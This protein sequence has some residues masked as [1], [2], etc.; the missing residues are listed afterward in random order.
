MKSG[1][2]L[3]FTVWNY[4][5]DFWGVGVPDHISHSIPVHEQGM[6]HNEI[7]I[8]LCLNHGIDLRLTDS[9]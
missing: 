3:P 1:L 6:S 8:L 4:D 9:W 7:E 5:I 2:P